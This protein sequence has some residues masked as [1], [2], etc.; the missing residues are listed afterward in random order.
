MHARPKGIQST[1]PK[2]TASPQLNC[3]Q[4]AQH[5]RTTRCP[6]TAATDAQLTPCE[7]P[8]WKACGNVTTNSPAF[9]TTRWTGTSRA[10]A[11]KGDIMVVSCAARCQFGA[12][13]VHTR[14]CCS[15]SGASSKR[16]AM[17]S[18]KADSNAADALAGTPYH[19][20]GAPECR[21]L[22]HRA[23]TNAT[24]F[25]HPTR[26][27]QCYENKHHCDTLTESNRSGCLRRATQTSQRAF[28]STATER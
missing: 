11:K 2:L 12:Q 20:F 28:R 9:W 22:H 5:R 23:H 24:D 7:K 27:H 13:S 8:A 14:T 18:F 3:A 16:S 1:K 10:M 26:R 17:C 6:Q 19:V 4:Q 15:R 25:T 21:Y